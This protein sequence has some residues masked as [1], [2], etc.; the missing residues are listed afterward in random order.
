MLSSGVLVK[1]TAILKFNIVEN[2]TDCKNNNYSG[3]I[4]DAK[5]RGAGENNDYDN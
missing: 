3:N 1:I 4:G 2:I 5:A